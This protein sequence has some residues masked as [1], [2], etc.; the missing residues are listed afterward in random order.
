MFISQSKAKMR[1]P[2]NII[3]IN[4]WIEGIPRHGLGNFDMIVSTGVLH[5]LKNPQKGLNM[6]NDIEFEHG[7]AQFMVYGKYGRTGVYQVQELLRS[8]NQQSQS[9][10][11]DLNSANVILEVLPTKHWFRHF[12]FP[13]TEIFEN[14]GIYDL[15]LHKRDVSYSIRELHKWLEKGGYHF[16]DFSQN[17][18]RTNLSLNGRKLKALKLLYKKLLK[19]NIGTQQSI[20]EVIWGRVFQQDFFATKNRN[21]KN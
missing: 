16:V 12:T 1:G 6:L 2:L 8:I 4:D 7:G 18:D 5:H 19:M 14:G 10:D 9:I 13:D 11:D 15:L 21:L 20:S 17:Q 3:W